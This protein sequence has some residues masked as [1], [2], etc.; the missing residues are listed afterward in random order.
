[1]IPPTNIEAE[2]EARKSIVS[3]VDIVCD[4]QLDDLARRFSSL[5][6]LKRVTAYILRFKQITK[7]K[8]NGQ[9]LQPNV[10]ELD[11]A[12]QFWLKF[13]QRKAFPNALARLQKGKLINSTDSL[14][15]LNP[16]IGRDGLLR[17][18]GR[19]QESSL[20]YDQKH[21][22]ILP[23]GDAITKLII[24]EVH[25]LTLHGGA[26][27]MLN[28]LRQKYWLIAGRRIINQFIQKC[29]KCCRVKG[30][31]SNQIMGNLPKSRVTIGR[32]FLRSGVDYAGPVKV[33]V[34]TSNSRKF[35]TVKGYITVF[36]CMATKSIR[37]E[38]VSDMTSEAFIAA[39]RRFVSR[40]GLCRELVSD[41]GSNFVGAKAELDELWT[42]LHNQIDNDLI[43]RTLASKGIDWHMHPA[44][45]PHFS[46][47][48]EAGV[49][50]TKFHLRRVMGSTPFT[51]EEW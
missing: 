13:Y 27:V 32:P 48:F 42:L 18:G 7:T 16:I 1:M 19:L 45:A 12:L 33:R 24:D 6:K 14:I 39:L 35:T 47:L 5:D 51:F 21:Q 46:G 26:Q 11:N 15:S 43:K 28:H 20:K 38:A 31:T 49:K 17:V 25:K 8:A 34:P 41:N 9:F 23:K 4:D 22:I 3:C 44:G 29:V 10:L 40:R 2:K 37:L 36:V 50:S 30:Q